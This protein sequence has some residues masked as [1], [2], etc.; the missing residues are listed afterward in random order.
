MSG[1]LLVGIDGGGSGCRARAMTAGGQVIG[2]GRGGPAQLSLGAAAA[3]ASAQQAITAAL[4]GHDP[5]LAVFGFGLAGGHVAAWRQAFE[6]AAPAGWR[7]V[8]ETDAVSTLLGAHGG[9]AGVAVGIGTGTFACSFDA[10]QTYHEAG[11]WGFTSGDEG[12]GGWLGV[13]LARK[14]QQAVD[15]RRP[16]TPLAA[17][18]LATIGPDRN[19]LFDWVGQA[20]Q[21]SYGA[22]APIAVQAAAEGDDEA[23]HLLEEA[24][25]EIHRLIDAVDHDKAAPIALLGGLASVMQPYLPERLRRRIRPARGDSADGALILARRLAAS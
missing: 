23:R 8:V 21:A 6:T 15:G 20:T 12:S 17:R 18:V 4:G 25:E 16:M 11:G 3:W 1:Q 22:L 10:S 14:A 19:G 24:A 5:A 13:R 2:E 9:E 7:L